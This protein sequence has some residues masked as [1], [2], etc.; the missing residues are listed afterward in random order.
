MA[1]YFDR[2][3]EFRLNA[4]VL[5]IPGLFIPPS[6]SDIT[7]VYNLGKTRLDKISQTYYNIPYYNWLILL[8][9]PQYGGL[10]FNIP[11]GAVIRVPVPLN[12][13]LNSYNLQVEKYKT[14]YG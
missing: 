12:D 5:P 3:S 10:E 6:S 14:L 1:G 9:N 7:V 2:Y 11:D 13:A 4:E 8:A